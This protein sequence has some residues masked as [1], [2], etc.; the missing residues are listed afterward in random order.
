MNETEVRSQLARALGWDEAHAGF[1]RA[2][3]GIA[4]EFR[5]PVDPELV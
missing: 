5:G 3:D 2:V 4:A 1:D